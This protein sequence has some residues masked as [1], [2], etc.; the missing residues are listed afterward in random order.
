MNEKELAKLTVDTIGLLVAVF[1]SNNI[2]LEEL[3]TNTSLKIRFLETYLKEIEDV[4]EKG[5]VRD[6]ILLIKKI[7]GNNFTAYST[8]L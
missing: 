1:Q 6:T 8:Q 2:S 7:I 4:E 3:Y 5:I